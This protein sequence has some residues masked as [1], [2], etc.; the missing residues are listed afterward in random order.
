[1]TNCFCN[2]IHSIAHSLTR[3][4]Y[5]Q[6]V[7]D[8]SNQYHK[9]QTPINGIYIMFEESELAHNG[10]RIVRIGTHTGKNNLQKRIR[11]HFEVNNKDRSIFRK[12]IG[13]AIISERGDKYLLE[14]WNI[15]MTTRAA[16]ELYPYLINSDEIHEIEMLVTKYIRENI[17]FAILPLPSN[18]CLEFEKK[19]IA[20]V[21]LCADCTASENW[22]G[23]N[24]PSQRIRNSSL[25]LVQHL[26]KRENIITKEDFERLRNLI[27][28]V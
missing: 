1:M 28:N 12:N 3:I 27:K 7:S 11:E 2:E 14:K 23:R 4:S 20:T 16:K 18:E 25:W 21:S 10:D 6:S 26:F 9:S 24:S 19:L 5:H 17:S 8:L 15:D 22:L 13:R